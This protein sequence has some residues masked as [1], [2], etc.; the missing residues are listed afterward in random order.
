MARRKQSLG[1]YPWSEGLA[2]PGEEHIA[3]I[4]EILGHEMAE[5]FFTD[6][7]GEI[8]GW[9]CRFGCFYDLRY[10]AEERRL[11]QS[12]RN[13]AQKLRSG[14][15]ALGEIG[16]VVLDEYAYPQGVSNPRFLAILAGIEEVVD[17]LDE[18]S[19]E[20]VNAAAMQVQAIAGVLRHHGIR[21]TVSHVTRPT[22]F[23]PSPFTRLV[24]HIWKIDPR[25]RLYHPK[26]LD[27]WPNFSQWLSARL[28]EKA[29]FNTLKL[30]K[31]PKLE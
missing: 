6:L 10:G 18:M 25:L 9:L 14:L 7:F 2:P 28:A 11:A 17:F 26:S 16:E 21:E 31:R 1:F 8:D 22:Q 19:G 20:E 12:V 5:Q 23:E 30:L 29:D 27:Y 24:D 3:A 13:S 4:R 15:E